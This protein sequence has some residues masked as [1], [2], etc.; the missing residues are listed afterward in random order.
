MNKKKGSLIAQQ[1]QAK[2][3]KVEQKTGKIIGGVAWNKNEKMELCETILR[4]P[5][6]PYGA[7]V[8]CPPV[9]E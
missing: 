2:R 3:R 4:V 5:P 6:P 7:P 1:Y 8:P 9:R